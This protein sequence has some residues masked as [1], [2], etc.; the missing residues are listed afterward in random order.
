MKASRPSGRSRIGRIGMMLLTLVMAGAYLWAYRLH[1]SHPHIHGDKGWWNW[2]DQNWYF[3]AATA[4]S[5]LDLDPARHLY[6]PGYALLAAPLIRLMSVHAFVVPNLLCLLISLW[7]FSALASRLLPRTLPCPDLIGGLVFAATT[8]GSPSMREVWV[9][10][11]STTGSIPFVYGALLA[12]VCFIEHRDRPRLVFWVGFAGGCIAGFRPADAIPVLLASGGGIAL[13]LIPGRPDLRAAFQSILWGGLG[14]GCAIVVTG[15]PYLA[16]YGFHASHYVAAS[17]VIGFEWRFLPLHWVLLGLDPRPLVDDGS[18]LVEAFFWL[19]LGLVACLVHVVAP[20]RPAGRLIHLTVATAACLHI[21]VYLCYRDL[22]PEGFF[23]YWNYHYYKWVMPVMALYALIL[24]HDLACEPRRAVTGT[25]ALAGLAILL[26]WRA[27]LDRIMPLPHRTSSDPVHVLDFTSGL[28]S[29][30]DVIL[31]AAAGDWNAIYGGPSSLS[32]DGRT[33]ADRADYKLLPAP[34][35]FLLVPLRPLADGQARLTVGPDLRLDPTATPLHARQTLVIGLPCWL[36]GHAERCETPLLLP[37]PVLPASGTIR[38]LGAESM[39]L[40]NGWSGHEPAGR[41]TDSQTAIVRARLAQ[42][43]PG[44]LQLR[45]TASAYV[46][47]GS[48]PLVVHLQVD[49]HDVGAWTFTTGDTTMR[50][51]TI[52]AAIVDVSPAIDI[53]LSID[54]P[55]SPATYAAGSSDHRQLGLFVRN[56]ALVPQPP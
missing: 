25:L 54:N 3:S 52:P 15:I 48:A 23:R 44:P 53:R 4:W 55:R 10:P 32:I 19:P 49:A 35:G 45:L 40:G 37:P 56:L 46:P 1:P 8:L 28:H 39:F 47:P 50:E 26:P 31:I 24:V 21:A 27:E 51:V 17:G 13:A 30:R 18:G 7:L 42:P 20:P 11:W 2:F 38:F 33:Y 12:A 16:I 41:W 36:P 34:G 29:V 9:V 22:Y 5:D 43:R 14:L 6:L